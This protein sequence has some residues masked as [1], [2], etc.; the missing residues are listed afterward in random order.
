MINSIIV[1]QVYLST[2]KPHLLDMALW[3]LSEVR[4]FSI[5]PLFISVANRIRVD[6][7]EVAA[8]L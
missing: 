7:S 6:V 4:F 8:Q 1:Q 2:K 5:D 3:H